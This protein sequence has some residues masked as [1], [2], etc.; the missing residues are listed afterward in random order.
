MG[1]DRQAHDLA[2][3]FVQADRII[4]QRYDVQR[5]APVP[6]ETRGLVA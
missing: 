5:L 2:A 4:R 3:G 6:L 1:Q